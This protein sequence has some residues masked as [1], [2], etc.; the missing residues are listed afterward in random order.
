MIDCHWRT[1][2]ARA[3]CVGQIGFRQLQLHLSVGVVKLYQRLALFNQI[4][5]IGQHAD[6]G[7]GDL[8]CD[9]NH[10]AADIGIV[11]GDPPASVVK[12]VIAAAAGEQGEQGGQDEQRAAALCR[13]ESRE[14]CPAVARSSLR[15]SARRTLFQMRQPAAQQGFELGGFIG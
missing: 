11:G 7:A 1:G 2:R 5:V 6:H 12:P 3:H 8:R 15:I 13:L 10:I 4:S 9:L 14:Q